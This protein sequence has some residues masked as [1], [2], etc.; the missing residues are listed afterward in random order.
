MVNTP[1]EAV[2]TLSCRK[3]VVRVSVSVCAFC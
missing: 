2:F 3:V 1:S